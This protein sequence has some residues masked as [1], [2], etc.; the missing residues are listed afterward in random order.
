MFGRAFVNTPHHHNLK[1]NHYFYFMQYKIHHN[2]DN[3]IR[4]VMALKGCVSFLSTAICICSL[5]ESRCPLWAIVAVCFDAIQALLM[6]L[7]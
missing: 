5:Y 1:Q 4:A 7:S 3:I 2:N 6:L